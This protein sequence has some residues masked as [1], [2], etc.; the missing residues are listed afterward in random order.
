MDIR[1]YDAKGDL[2]LSCNDYIKIVWEEC[3][4]GPGESEVVFIKS[5]QVLDLLIS[6]KNLIAEYDGKQGLVFD[7]FV[8]NENVYLKVQSL[9]TLL[10]RRIIPE[11]VYTYYGNPE[12]AVIQCIKQYAS[13]ISVPSGDENLDNKQIALKK[14]TVFDVV[15]SA[16]KDLRKGLKISFLPLEKVYSAEFIHPKTNHIRLSH[17]NRN[18]SD[19]IC[20]GNINSIKNAGYYTAYFIDCGNWEKGHTYLYNFQPTNFMKQYIAITDGYIEGLK[21]KE[22]QYIYC[23]TEDGEL[24]VSDVKQEFR[25][26]YMSLEEN[27]IL[28]MEQDLRYLEKDQTSLYLQENN[29]ITEMVKAIPYEPALDIGEIVWVEKSIGLEKGL[30]KMQV[31]SVKTDTSKPVAEVKLEAIN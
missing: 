28:V 1:F 25:V 4:L 16:L 5:H 19:I 3:L 31:I 26:H 2:R 13:Y 18:L 15:S 22:G 23:D 6:E 29:K 10:T 8:Q 30:I 11:D 24:K 7:Y 17:G 21:V 27:P 20:E 14:P 12:T 9:I